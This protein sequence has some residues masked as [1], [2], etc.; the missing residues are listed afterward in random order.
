V[1][2]DLVDQHAHRLGLPR[3]VECSAALRPR[4]PAVALEDA[5]STM[6]AATPYTHLH[7]LL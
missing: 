2:R 6:K 1:L 5:V 3:M 7:A 4:R